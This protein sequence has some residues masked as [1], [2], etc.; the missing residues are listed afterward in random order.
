MANTIQ[1]SVVADVAKFNR[2]ISG[3]NNQLGTL[4]KVSQ[5]AGALLGKSL[6]VAGLGLLGAGAA[7]GVYL[8]GAVSA[9]SDL[10]ETVS[11]TKTIFG[12]SGGAILKWG[13]QAAS[14]LGL[15]K[16]EALDGVS[17]FGNFFN[18]I[19]FGTKD[20]EKMSKGL[21]RAAVDLGSFHNAAAPEV[22]EAMAAAT[23]GEYD[24]L[25]KYIPTINAAAVE[26]KALAI[27]GKQNVKSLT[28]QDKAM[29]VHKLVLGGLGKAQGDFNRTQGSAAN[30]QKILAARMENVKAKIGSAL[31]PMWTALVGV[32]NKHVVP[33]MAKFATWF[34]QNAP[35]AVEAIRAKFEQWMPTIKSV[36]GFLKDNA[37]TI[38]KVVA[39]F[40]AVVAVV[41]AVNKAMAVY[42][43]VVKVVQAVTKAWT[44][45]QTAFNFV[46][47]MNPIALV[48]IAIVALVAAL[49]I[50]YKR[51]DKFRA[52]V[53]KAFN[54]IKNVALKV[55]P[56]IKAVITTVFNVI[57]S[58]VTTAVRVVRT[59]VT[60]VWNGLRSATKAVWDRIRRYVIDPVSAIVTRV[61]AGVAFIRAVWS[62][63]WDIVRSKVSAVW[64]TITSVVGN[65]I[66]SV[67]TRI[68]NTLSNIR[69]GWALAWGAVRER[70]S[71]VWAGI[72]TTVTNAIGNV[73][74]KVRG[75]KGRVTGALSGAGR[76]LYSAGRDLLAGLI[77]GI[78]DKVGDAVRA[79]QNAVSSVVSGA[80]N[81]LGIQSPS[82][83]FKDIGKY[84]VLGLAEGLKQ[85]YDVKRAAAGMSAAVVN[86][87][88]QPT[89]AVNVDTV[90]TASA[91]GGALATA[92][93]ITINVSSLD[94]AGASKAVV[95]AIKSYER[96][97]GTGWRR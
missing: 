39:G 4:G 74:D 59:V 96:T 43:G 17:V 37:G 45:V 95:E 24:S 63:A 10:G 5:N 40:Y 7:A 49:V 76:W 25:Q 70:L 85:T 56:A 31:L 57:R 46:M 75:I 14:S 58:V 54:A 97:N 18:Q 78:T 65:A 48:V 2:G 66:T 62:A 83:V 15:S 47:A 12:D 77:G 61:R 60:T 16:Q 32:V 91:H 82:K 55:F 88:Q 11:K 29:A 27:T 21:V 81:L 93:P 42:N 52:I 68:S 90:S 38:V 94:P 86:G 92:A 64:S 71:A 28:A 23:R 80:K 50:A 34:G 44:A 41:A 20:T 26:Q 13:N 89:L 1:V 51:S 19:G 22:M 67:R 84:T 3:V 69:T 30:Q 8:K 35:K 6:K 53:D 72:R 87:F 36:G 79:V 73:M 33:A 9:A